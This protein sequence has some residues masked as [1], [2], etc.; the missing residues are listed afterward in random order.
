MAKSS[1][2]QSKSDFIRGFNP[3]ASA[4]EVVAAG[5]KAGVT[6]S[7][8]YVYNVRNAARKKAGQPPMRPGRPKGSGR[9]K[10]AVVST[11]R[12][13]SSARVVA[14]AASGSALEANFRRMALELG[15][16]RASQLVKELEAG[17]DALIKG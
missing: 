14:R 15:L 10:G 12:K 16:A 17:V 1:K 5:Q 13:R 9:S 4:A 8:A 2:G 6:M 7:A 3:S 11:A